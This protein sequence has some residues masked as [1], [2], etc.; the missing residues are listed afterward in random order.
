[1]R[2]GDWAFDCDVADH[3]G[4]H[5]GW[6]EDGE[7]LLWVAPDDGVVHREAQPT[8]KSK[9]RT[10]LG[11]RYA[12]DEFWADTGGDPAELT[13]AGSV[14]FENTYCHRYVARIDFSMGSSVFSLGNG[15]TA[16]IGCHN[17]VELDGASVVDATPYA[18]FGLNEGALASDL[19]L[20]TNFYPPTLWPVYVDVDPGETLTATLTGM[21]LMDSWGGGTAEFVKADY[22][23]NLQLLAWPK[24][25]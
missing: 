22:G 7:S 1:M 8:V 5:C 16:Y 9:Y 6:T 2:E 11:A 15:T 14:T 19:T 4:L 10:T 23:W 18:G 3:N 17:E 24:G 20:A 12:T 13:Q 21:G 25:T